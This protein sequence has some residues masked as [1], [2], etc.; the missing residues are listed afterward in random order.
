MASVI[1]VLSTGTLADSSLR[2]SSGVARSHRIPG[3]LYS[4]NDS[5]NAP[6][7]FALDSTGAALGRW[8]LPALDNRDWEAIASG[9]CPAGR[10]LFIGD[11]GDNLEKRK[12]VT[13]YRVAEPE[14]LDAFRGKPVAR[15]TVVDS[16]RF[17][18]PGGPRD[19]EAMWIDA[20]GAPY[21]VS[22]G[23]SGQITLYRVPPRFGTKKVQLAQR[24][25]ALPITPQPA[26]GQW[27]TDAALSPDGH[28]VAIRTYTML[29]IFTLSPDGRLDRP[30]RCG[31]AGLEPQ[32][33]GVEWLDDRRL[34]LTSESTN[35]KPAPVHVVR[36]GAG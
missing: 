29:Y 2:E 34:F 23:R 17:R 28:Q 9:P 26:L 18:Y 5:G 7:I 27:V 36:C 35:G 8:A 4:I 16:L 21:V 1:E 14:T 13:I 15:A 20:A 30:T 3:V 24:V 10:C 33:E 11:L 22:K 31:L 6:E 32:G 25:Q 19:V 12:H